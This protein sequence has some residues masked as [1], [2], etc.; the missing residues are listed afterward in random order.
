M[1]LAG[2]KI[3][4]P[5]INW[6]FM[7]GDFDIAVQEGMKEQGMSGPYEL[8]TVD[9][10]MLITHGVDPISKAPACTSCHASSGN[11]TD[12]ALMVPFGKL[13]YHTWPAK[14]LGCSLCH[15]AKKLSFANMHDKHRA[16]LRKCSNCHTKEPTGLVKVTSDL[17]ND[18]HSLATWAG[19]ASHKK[20][21][22]RYDCAQCHK[23]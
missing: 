13:G 11:T 21:V 20:H 9:A 1:P 7:T 2:G 23:F 17:C 3:V 14:V 5:M 19:A 18:C 15:T 22:T 4:P 6:M 8:V 10:E 12:G 16:P